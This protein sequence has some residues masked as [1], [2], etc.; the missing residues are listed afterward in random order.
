M[1]GWHA[2]TTVLAG[3]ATLGVAAGLGVALYVAWLY[4]RWRAYHRH[5]GLDRPRRSAVATV[6]VQALEW[7]ALVRAGG[8]Q[9][10]SRLHGRWMEPRGPWAG[11]PVVLVHGFLQNG[12]G[13]WAL[14][15]HLADRGRP[16]FSPHLGRPGRAPAAYATALVGALEQARSAWPD[17][18]DLIAHSMG[19]VV[20]RQALQQAPHLGPWLHRVVTVA[21]PHEGTALTRGLTQAPEPRALARGADYLAELPPLTTWVD[22]SRLHTVGG[23]DDTVVYPESTTRL[24]GVPH[25]VVTGVGHSGL[26]IHW[27]GVAWVLAAL[28]G[29]VP[30]CP[31]VGLTAGGPSP[32]GAPGCDPR[33]G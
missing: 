30:A 24:P 7:A 1:D 8:F 23:V 33:G 21:A 10:R 9:V 32:S 25:T 2:M 12:T 17:G 19:G 15:R 27:R 5:K 18:V 6:A 22:P 16:S 13:A 29:P 26:L 3:L 28:E 11:R 20:L 4:R 14:Q 31:G